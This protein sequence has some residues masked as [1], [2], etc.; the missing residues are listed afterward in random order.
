[1]IFFAHTMKIK[2]NFNKKA[3]RGSRVKKPKRSREE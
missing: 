1:L 2:V 3:R